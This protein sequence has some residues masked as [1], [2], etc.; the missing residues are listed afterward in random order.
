MCHRFFGVNSHGLGIIIIT[1]TLTC[2]LVRLLT[3]S[4]IHSLTHLP[5][6]PLT[7]SL[8]HPL[9]HSLIH[10]LTH[11]PTHPLTLSLVHTLTHSLTHSLTCSL[12]LVHTHSSLPLHSPDDFSSSGSH[13]EDQ[14]LIIRADSTG[15]GISSASSTSFLLPS[16]ADQLRIGAARQSFAF[17]PPVSDY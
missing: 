11:L 12:I 16:Q 13:M 4:L 10:S 15:S 1:H 17:L 14:T 6:H 5:T 7:L 9:T 3:H 8:T 2:P